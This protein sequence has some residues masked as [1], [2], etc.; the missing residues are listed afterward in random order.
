MVFNAR[1]FWLLETVCGF[2][3]KLTR[4]EWGARGSRMLVRHFISGAQEPALVPLLS[5]LCQVLRVV[6]CRASASSGAE[7][8]GEVWGKGGTWT[9]GGAAPAGR[10]AARVGAQLGAWGA[11]GF[12]FCVEA[13]GAGAGAGAAAPPLALKALASS[14][15]VDLEYE[16]AVLRRAA[17][18]GAP[19]VPAVEGS[20]QFL[21]AHDAATDGRE[22]CCYGGGY[23]ICGGASFTRAA[24][25]SAARCGAAFAA[26]W[27]LH[28]AGI[29]H[30]DA[31]L[32]NLLMRGCAGDGSGGRTGTDGDATGNATREE[33]LWADMR[34][35]NARTKSRDA[36][37]VPA[38]QNADA[39]ALAASVLR[40]AAPPLAASALVSDIAKALEGVPARG[41]A[42]YEALAAAVWAFRVAP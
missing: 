26:L 42:A 6:P 25:D 10:G 13:E 7:A 35:P 21:I 4:G 37:P 39:L 31:R 40:G 3:I 34:D 36:T 11:P 41:A 15:R 23:L 24:V 38:A 8:E 19:V 9:R 29:A 18:A 22:E 1:A 12:V 17:V 2:A 33:L 32:H 14:T 16:F 27:A 20:L 28:A 5:H 30:G